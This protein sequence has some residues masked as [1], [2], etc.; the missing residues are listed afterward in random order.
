MKILYFVIDAFAGAAFKGN[1]VGV[2]VLPNPLK[3]QLMQEIAERNN[4]P[5]TAFICR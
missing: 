1:P 5:E 2:C 3:P 4:L